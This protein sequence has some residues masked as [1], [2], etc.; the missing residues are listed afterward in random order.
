MNPLSILYH[1]Q[2]K[3]EARCIYFS[4]PHCHIVIHA[5]LEQLLIALRHAMQKQDTIR[6]V[7]AAP[8]FAKGEMR[9]I[10]DG[11]GSLLVKPRYS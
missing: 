5:A 9:L 1:V 4:V 7:N 2:S 11:F 10:K 6:V 8:Q 3:M